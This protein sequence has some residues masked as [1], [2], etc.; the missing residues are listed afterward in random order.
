MNDALQIFHTE[1]GQLVPGLEPQ[2]LHDCIEKLEKEY[3]YSTRQI[4]EVASY[5]FAMV[6]R[7]ALGFSAHQA[8]ALCLC[9]DSLAGWITL[10]CARQL[11]NAGTECELFIQKTSADLS[12]TARELLQYFRET[13]SEVN[14]VE[15]YEFHELDAQRVQSYHLALSGLVNLN[16]TNDTRYA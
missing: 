14:I 4:V 8:R 15:N 10:A 6:V 3:G 12:P 2:Q 1:S 13:H 7:V 11:Q 9:S 16:S 5:S